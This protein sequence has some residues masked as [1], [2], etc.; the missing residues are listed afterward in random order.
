MCGVKSRDVRFGG[1][2]LVG[3]LA[4]TASACGGSDGA[5]STTAAAATTAGSTTTP[6]TVGAST[7][8]IPAP[9]KTILELATEE[10]RLGTLLGLLDTAGLTTKL[11][12]DG[13]FTLIAPTDDAFKKMDPNT[14]DQIS[15]SPEVLTQLLSYHFVNGRVTQQDLDAGEVTTAEG[16]PI[17]LQATAQFPTL[18][19]QTV[20]RA[21]R[22][23]NGTI[24][25]IDTV[26]LP[27][28]LK[29]P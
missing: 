7:S 26:L 6:T 13:P 12:G 10:G 15:K 19:G 16:T 23:T 18:N 11:Q 24:L 5:T 4:V 8:S 21:G 20:V 1:V 17:A 9:T 3:L 2:I 14:L 28:D 29:L 27:V 25:L 22:A